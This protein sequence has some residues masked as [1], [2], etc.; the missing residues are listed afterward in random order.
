MDLVVLHQ[1]FHLGHLSN[2]VCHF[3]QVQLVCFHASPLLGVFDYGFGLFIDC[4]HHEGQ[5]SVSKPNP[6]VILVIQ[7]DCPIVCLGS[8][9]F[10]HISYII[11]DSLVVEVVD[12]RR[13]N[14]NTSVNYQEG[15]PWL[16]GPYSTAALIETLKILMRLLCYLFGQLALT[17]VLN[18]RKLVIAGAHSEQPVSDFISHSM[19]HMTLQEI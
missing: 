1:F 18:I 5:V 19:K 11:H 14:V 16:S 3:L 12:H 4:V 13:Y 15:S 9:I 7:V 6:E 10:T 2:H 17:L 8:A